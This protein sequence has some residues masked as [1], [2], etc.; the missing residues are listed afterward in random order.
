M[1]LK[2]GLATGNAADTNSGNY[3]WNTTTYAAQGAGN[4]T[5]GVQFNVSTRGYQDLLV[6]WDQRLSKTGS[7]YYR[8]QY[9]TNG[10]DFIDGPVVTVSTAET[11]Q[12][13]TNRLT[14]LPGVDD[15]PNFAFR[16][17]AEYEST[18][19]LTTNANYATASTSSY[20]AGGTVRYGMISVLASSLP[21]V[22]A[23]LNVLG[24]GPHWFQ[25]SATG[26]TGQ[27]YALE[28]STD[29]TIWTPVLTNVVPFTFT[30][31]NLCPETLRF[32]RAVAAP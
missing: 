32:Y 12:S 28:K 18:A 24:F 26:T 27:R 1:S 5:R 16:V 8:L 9:S 13:K 23:T 31:T 21:P 20:G 29:L 19:I 22:S 6:A 7:K 15:N 30:D 4:K 3:A 14:G 2:S 10:S 17:V 25:L 11:F